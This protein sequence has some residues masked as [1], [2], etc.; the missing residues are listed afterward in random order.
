MAIHEAGHGV[1]AV[2]MGV[3]TISMITI[4]SLHG[5]AYVA[6]SPGGRGLVTE[7]QL[8][9][10]M[11]VLLAGRATED[12]H[13]RVMTSGSG[14]DANSDLA[15]AT[16]LACDMEMRLGFGAH[17]PLVYR[18]TTDLPSLLATDQELL[19]RVSARLE[20]AYGVTRT[21]IETHERAID[22][23]A[24]MLL[25]YETLEGDHLAETLQTVKYLIEE[26]ENGRV[27][28]MPKNSDKPGW[29]TKD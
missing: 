13:C 4:R 2:C 18:D 10:Y 14:G 3:E 17:H 6:W 29:V 15:Q 21:V 25:E 28:E 7:H 12:L 27:P 20:R 19:A 16:R 22:F 9:G 1:A 23:L 5:N 8:M 26:S 24:G 11:V